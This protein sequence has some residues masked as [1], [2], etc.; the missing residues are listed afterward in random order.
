MKN[1]REKSRP[2]LLIGSYLDES[3]RRT[4]G[5]RRDPYAVTLGFCA[6]VKGLLQK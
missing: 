3:S 1:G 2:F 5:E 6:E 4:P